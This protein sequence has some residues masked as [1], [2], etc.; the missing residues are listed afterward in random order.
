MSD[1]KSATQ[2]VPFFARFLDK[3]ESEQE[4]NGK[5]VTKKYPSDNEDY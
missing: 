3:Q 5:P 2:A 1:K 4:S